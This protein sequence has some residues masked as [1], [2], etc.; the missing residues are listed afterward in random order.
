[1][2]LPLMLHFVDYLKSLLAMPKYPKTR[3]EGQGYTIHISAL[4]S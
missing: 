3:Q 2:P 4:I 1:M